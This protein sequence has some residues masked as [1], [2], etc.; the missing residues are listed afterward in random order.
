MAKLG[1]CKTCGKMV[2][3]E[4]MSCPHCGQPMPYS[5]PKVI[6]STRSHSR[7]LDLARQGRKIE[8]IKV[9]REETGLGLKEAK[10]LV[11]SWE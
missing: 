5:D 2:S 1:V 6:D 11:D 4:A 7:A 8:A 9:V 3:N 10:D